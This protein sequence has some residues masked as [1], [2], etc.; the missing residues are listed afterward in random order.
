MATENGISNIDEVHPTGASM[1]FE[2]ELN[3]DHVQNSDQA[4]KQDSMKL[5]KGKNEWVKLNVGGTIFMTTRTTL[6]RDHKS[7]LYRLIQE[8][9]DLNTDKV[10]TLLKVFRTFSNRKTLL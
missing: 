1:D 7:F 4:Q 2:V 9:P 8:E 5:R 10:G 3:H 6:G